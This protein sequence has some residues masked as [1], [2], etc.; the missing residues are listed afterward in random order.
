VVN[1]AVIGLVTDF[2]GGYF[3]DVE[4]FCNIFFVAEMILR[5]WHL[6]LMG[7]FMQPKNVFDCVLAMC[8]L[9]ELTQH[10][11]SRCL[12]QPASAAAVVTV[13]QVLRVLRLFRLMR[14]LKLLTVCRELRMIMDAFVQAFR[15]VAWVF[16]MLVIICYM[17]AI[18]LTQLVGQRAYWWGEDGDKI[19]TWF[20]TVG[21]S[22][23]TL[24]F[25][26]TQSEFDDIVLTLSKQIPG[27]LV[28]SMAS[29]FIMVTA[30][31]MM[32]LITGVI[33]EA[34]VVEQQ[35]D[36]ERRRERVADGCRECADSLRDLLS[37]FDQDGS[38]TLSHAEVTAAIETSQTDYN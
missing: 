34:M 3:M 36:E 15:S 30:Y 11:F 10:L 20:G 29:I 4:Q 32:N 6:G 1:A 38:G 22:M 14:L 24:V 5:I 31:T 27:P 19:T 17:C 13:M 33:C 18:F 35:K 23:R 12:G 28:V 25:V 2:G 9:A 37:T 21:H 7:Y 16:I 26:V 8:S